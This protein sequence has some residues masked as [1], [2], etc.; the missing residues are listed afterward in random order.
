MPPD[1]TE[2]ELKQILTIYQSPLGH[3]MIAEEP[4]IIDEGLQEADGWAD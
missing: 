2:A 4:K 3:K 1:F